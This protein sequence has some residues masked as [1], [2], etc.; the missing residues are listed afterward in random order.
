MVSYDHFRAPDDIPKSVLGA[1]FDIRGIYEGPFH[2]HRKAQLFFATEGVITVDTIEALWVTPPYR[3]VWV[4]SEV[5]HTVR[6]TGI[7]DIYCL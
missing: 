4:P 1:R 2:A 6:G 5:E 7:R 3:A